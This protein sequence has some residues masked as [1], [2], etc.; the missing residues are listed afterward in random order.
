[1]HISTR[2]NYHL[3]P[4]MTTIKK[5]GN[6]K[7]RRYEKM[8]ICTALGK[9]KCCCFREMYEG[10]SLKIKQWIIICYRLNMGVPL[11]FDGE[12]LQMTMVSLWEVNGS[13][14]WILLRDQRPAL[15]LPWEG[16]RRSWPLATKK[17]VLLPTWPCWAW[18]QTSTPRTG[19]NTFL[20]LIGHPL[21]FSV[22]GVRTDG[23]TV[24]SS[25][26]TCGDI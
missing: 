7:C 13:W 23:H 16:T 19:R 3:T 9:V 25:N 1:M 18:P 5:A 24:W 22:I 10:R 2:M 26:S 4:I 14:E 8:G 17:R 20:L 15:F 21:G 12:I 11:Q 6:N